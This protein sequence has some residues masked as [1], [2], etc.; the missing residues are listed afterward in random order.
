MRKSFTQIFSVCLLYS[1]FYFSCCSTLD[2]LLSSCIDS[3]SCV[4]FFLFFLFLYFS[5]AHSHF[6]T[7]CS[8]S[9]PPFYYPL[10][11]NDY[12]IFN[13]IPFYFQCFSCVLFS[14]FIVLRRCRSRVFFFSRFFPF[15]FISFYSPYLASLK[16]ASQ[17]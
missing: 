1:I 7:I 11:T 10:R 3:F 15:S 9:F 8:H 5:P 2:S 14:L 13:S 16:F 17:K 4:Q 12:F 6:S